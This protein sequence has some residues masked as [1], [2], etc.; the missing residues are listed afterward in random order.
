VSRQD[1]KT[2]RESEWRE[3][4]D[5]A[6]EVA[7]VVV[8]AA[9]EVH[10][11]LGPAFLESVYENA[12]CHELSMR[13]VSFERQV[14]IAVRYKDL[15]V[16]EGR[17]DLVVAGIVVVELKALPTLTPLHVAQVISYLKATGIQLGLLLNFGG[18]HL[19]TGCRRIV[20]SR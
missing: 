18:R 7:S 14:S 8:D 15:V 4:N 17:M 20:L 12:L 2:P 19:K 11:L 16:G 1:A 10:W 5:V 13:G 6:D 9:V 3:P